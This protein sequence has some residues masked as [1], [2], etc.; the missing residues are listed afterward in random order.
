LLDT[1]LA[2]EPGDFLKL[3]AGEAIPGA[4]ALEIIASRQ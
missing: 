3:G 1:A 2:G 4:R